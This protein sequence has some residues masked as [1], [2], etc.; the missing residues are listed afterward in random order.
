MSRAGGGLLV[1]NAWG[2]VTGYQDGPEEGQQQWLFQCRNTGVGS[3]N[4][5]ATAGTVVL[6]FGK[7]GAGWWWVTTTDGAMGAVFMQP[8]ILADERRP[9]RDGRSGRASSRSA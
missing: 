7:S 2:Q 8:T 3:A 4:Q 6:G 5:I 9:A 1:A